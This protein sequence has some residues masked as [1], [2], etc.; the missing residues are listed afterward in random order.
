M[1]TDWTGFYTCKECHKSESLWNHIT[2]DHKV[3]EKLEDRR[4]VGKSSCNS[5][6]GMDQRVQSLMFMV[7]MM[8][9]C[10]LSGGQLFTGVHCCGKVYTWGFPAVA[11]FFDKGERY[12]LA[13]QCALETQKKLATWASN[14]LITHPILRIWPRRTTTCSLDRKKTIE[15]WPFFVRRGGHCCRGDLVGRENFWFFLVA[16]RSYSKGLRSLLNFVGS[17]L[18]KSRVWSL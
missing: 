17:M 15:R 3:G 1:N 7:M 2:T 5:G 6:D 10:I 11:C 12:V 16:C 9:V 13:R 8:M 4:N 18:N 14:V